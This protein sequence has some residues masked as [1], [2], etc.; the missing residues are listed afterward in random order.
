MGGDF[1]A[2]WRVGGA[3]VAKIGVR[4]GFF[5]PTTGYSLPDAVRNAVLLADQRS[6]D[7]AALHDLF[8]REGD[9]TW[10]RRDFYRT[11]NTMMFK[12]AA[13]N[14]RYKILERFYRLDPALISRFYAGRTSMLDKMKIMTGKP[15]VPVGKAVEALR[16]RR[17]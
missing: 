9:S 4:G 11:L 7:G 16:D 13:P 14:E 8:E 3:R 1:H 15:P 10:R 12:A 17:R 5:H 6:F 2:F